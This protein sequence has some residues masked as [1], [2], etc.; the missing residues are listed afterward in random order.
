MIDNTDNKFCS[1][2]EALNFAVDKS[3]G[4]YIVFVH[5]DILFEKNDVLE[6]IY[7]YVRMLPDK[8]LGAAG[9][10]D[11]NGTITN[12]KHGIPP[13]QAGEIRVN[14][15]EKVQTLDECLFIIPKNLF[16]KVNFDE[17]SIKN[18]HLYAV[19]YCLEA[20]KLDIESYVIDLNG[21]Y[22]RSSGFSMNEHYYSTL[23]NIAKKHRNT[24]KYIYTTMGNWPTNRI[25]L[26]FYVLKHKLKRLLKKLLLI[27]SNN[28][29]KKQCVIGKKQQKNT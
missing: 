14:G 20:A 6:K 11:K 15:F 17:K 9:K 2:A 24:T 19:D 1:A 26:E 21:V 8:I 12:I 27:L 3:K 29:I 13:R 7:E 18:W 10:N 16:Y 25:V 23:R 22:H 5:Q 4:D 28:T